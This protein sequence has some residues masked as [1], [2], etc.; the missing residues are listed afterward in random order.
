[1]PWLLIAGVLAAILAG[2]KYSE[3]SKAH[4]A[5]TRA[6]QQLLDSVVAVANQAG[7]FD[8]GELG[9]SGARVD[10]L[11]TVLEAA[12][13]AGFNGTV[14]LKAHAGQFCMS[15]APS[16]ELYVANDQLAIDECASVGMNGRVA[17][18]QTETLSSRFRELLD[19]HPAL[20]NQD[21]TVQ[22]EGVGDAQPLVSY[23]DANTVTTAGDWNSVAR[24]NNRVEFQL[25]PLKRK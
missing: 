19:V 8:A 18:R 24:A 12:Q 17:V 5:A 2:A 7:R 9:F 15:Q 21:L 13:T 25:I 3:V 20:H 23:P 14:L 4:E 10:L 22:V 11:R 1:M 6:N 16:G